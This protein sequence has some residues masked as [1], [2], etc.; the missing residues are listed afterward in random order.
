MPIPVAVRS[1]V[2][3]RLVAGIAGLNP[4]EGTDVHPLC[5]FCVV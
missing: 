1:N 4:A 2:Y 3:S 5:L